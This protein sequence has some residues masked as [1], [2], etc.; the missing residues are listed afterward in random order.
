MSSISGG[1]ESTASI[2]SVR[3]LCIAAAFRRPGGYVYLGASL[4]PTVATTFNT[5]IERFIDSSV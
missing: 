5:P 2:F 1:G 4:K 3:K